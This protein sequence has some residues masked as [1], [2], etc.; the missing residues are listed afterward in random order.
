MSH[1]D[2]T[3]YTA[4][5]ASL[6][7]E[8]RA[9]RRDYLH[10]PP[11]ELE[12]KADAIIRSIRRTE[13]DT[14]WSADHPAISHPFPGME[15]LTGREIVVQTR[16]F[17]AL[18][19]MPKGALLHAHLDATVDMKTLYRL[20]LKHHAI[21]I[22]VPTRLTPLNMVQNLSTFRALPVGQFT[23]HTSLHDAPVGSWVPLQA[24]RQNFGEQFGGP[25]G[26]DKWVVSC[27][28]ITPNEAYGTHN[29]VK[30]IW[31]R[32]ISLF[33][34]TDGLFL[35]A[36]IFKEYVREF[37]FTFIND[38]ISY[39]E[40]RI[41]FFIKTMVGPDGQ[42]N[43]PHREWVAMFD[44]VQNEVKADMKAKGRDDEFLGARIIYTTVRA[45]SNEEL[46]WHMKNCISLKKEFPHLIAGKFDLV[47]DENLLNPLIYYAEQLLRFPQMQKDAGVGEIPY[48]FH[49]GETLGDGT[50]A[51]TNLFDAVLL[52]TKRIGH[53][54]SLVKHPKL[55][56]LCRERDIPLEVCPISCRLTSSMPMHPLS[57]LINHGVPLALCSDDP[58]KWA[59]MGLSFDF[60]QVLVSSEVSGLLTLGQL[61]RDSIYYSTLDERAKRAAV[62]SWEKRWR[63]FLEYVV[64]QGVTARDRS[65]SQQ[66]FDQH[67][68]VFTAAYGARILPTVCN[69]VDDAVMNL[70]KENRSSNTFKLW[71]SLDYSLV[72]TSSV[73]KD[74]DISEEP[75]IRTIFE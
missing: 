24:A 35:F 22:T 58:G 41:N 16:I 73:D 38:G 49:A 66:G 43:I 37:F 72:L 39:M 57:T 47:G 10:G 5:R 7:A 31:E 23:T 14:I 74:L 28:V 19:K 18:C 70:I 1:P 56:Q 42:D 2:F 40:P 27:M 67:T 32:F 4:A 71:P 13:A 34:V 52:G 26:F 68:Q 11:S 51:D 59:S 64:E 3:S 55:M 60:Y 6:I 69:N 54:F 48:I 33:R 50:E 20:A 63:S 21:H 65:G 44:E 62:D 9:L 25:E 15:F 53:G 36:P 12:T 17:K 8:D 30:K 45:I 29:T 46:G 75:P 61:A